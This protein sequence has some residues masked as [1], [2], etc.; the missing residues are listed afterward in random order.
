[1]EY[2]IRYIPKSNDYIFDA[3]IDADT[4]ENAIRKLKKMVK[5]HRIIS[6]EEER[7]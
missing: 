7:R 4:K 2:H 6:V 1:M 5:V 3:W